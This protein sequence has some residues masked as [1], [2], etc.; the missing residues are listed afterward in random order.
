MKMLGE[1]A[2]KVERE[3]KQTFFFYCRQGNL[4]LLPDPGIYFFWKIKNTLL[5]KQNIKSPS[6]SSTHLIHWALN[7]TAPS[8]RRGGVEPAEPFSPPS[9]SL[10]LLPWGTGEGRRREPRSAE[11]GEEREGKR[12]SATDHQQE[13]CFLCCAS[14]SPK[15]FH[16]TGHPGESEIKIATVDSSCSYTCKIYCGSVTNCITKSFSA[17]WLPPLL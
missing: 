16:R 5:A 14:P 2:I 8:K 15:C 10:L 9:S 4:P 6:A 11:E 13:Q 1:G 17:T 3:T 12:H 7:I